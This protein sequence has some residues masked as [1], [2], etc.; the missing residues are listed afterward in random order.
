MHRLVDYQL[1]CRGMDV[2]MKGKNEIMLGSP[3]QMGLVNAFM[4]E[5]LWVNNNIDD[6]T[7]T[8]LL[9]ELNAYSG[10]V[11]ANG[12]YTFDSVIDRD[13]Y[14]DGLAHAWSAVQA[15]NFDPTMIIRK[16]KS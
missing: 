3:A 4:E 13:H 1:N 10:K 11:L 9:F 15:G 7:S 14:V 6:I 5:Q 8:E 16:R 2:K 12:L